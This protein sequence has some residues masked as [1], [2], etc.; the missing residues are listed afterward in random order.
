MQ[1]KE[2]VGA[3]QLEVGEADKM[4][5]SAIFQSLM[6]DLNSLLSTFDNDFEAVLKKNGV[7]R[8]VD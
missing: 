1:D 2:G 7:V 3:Y 5:A 6:N 8:R 4:E